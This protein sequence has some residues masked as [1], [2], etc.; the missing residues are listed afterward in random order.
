MKRFYKSVT[1]EETPDGFRFLLDCKPV[2]TP[3]R[4]SLILPTRPLAEAIAEEWSA[5]KEE[6][7]PWFEIEQVGDITGRILGG[8]VEQFPGQR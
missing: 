8:A 3:A 2:L 1:V 4:Q 7:A 6:I 5:Q